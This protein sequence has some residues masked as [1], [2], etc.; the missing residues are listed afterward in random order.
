MIADRAVGLF[1]S[2]PLRLLPWPVREPRRAW[3]AILVGAALTLAGS[4]ALSSLATSLAPAL[5]KPDFPMRGPV[6]FLLLF[7]FAPFVETLI[8]AAI[9]TVLARFISPTLAVLVSAA[10]WGIAH[11]LQAAAWGLVIWWPFVIFSTLYMVWR[12]RSVVAALAVA[13]ATH[14]LQNLLPA[15]QIAFG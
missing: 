9:L 2:G 6:A 5:G 10:L 12:E 1:D 15:L 11:S 3:L 14:A 13:T 4:L 8:M 7:A